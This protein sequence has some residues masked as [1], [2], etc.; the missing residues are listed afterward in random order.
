MNRVEGENTRIRHYLDRLH[1][2][3]LQRKNFCYSKLF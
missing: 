3:R 2:D 1:R